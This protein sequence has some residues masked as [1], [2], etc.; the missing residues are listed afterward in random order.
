MSRASRPRQTPPQSAPRPGPGPSPFPAQPPGS[1]AVFQHDPLDA[2]L[3]ALLSAPSPAAQRRVAAQ[4]PA[5]TVQTAYTQ[6]P[7]AFVRSQ[8][9][10]GQLAQ[11]APHYAA[12]YAPVHAPRDQH[13]QQWQQQQLYQQQQQQR[14]QQE[15]YLQQQHGPMLPPAHEQ[16]YRVNNNNS[17]G[18]NG[19]QPQYPHQ[20]HHYAAATASNDN[21]HGYD[22]YGGYYSDSPASHQPQ[23][24]QY[25]QQQ[26]QQP[27]R[28]A[29]G[30][31][32]SQTQG[33]ATPYTPQQHH[34]SQQHHYQKQQQQQQSPYQQGYE[35]G[36]D[37]DY[38]DYQ[39]GQRPQYQP[40]HHQQQQQQ[41]QAGQ[42]APPAVMPSPA[43]VAAYDRVRTQPALMQHPR[44]QQQQQIGRAHV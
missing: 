10:H 17:H 18:Y 28:H 44:L 1:A 11:H 5:A 25:F 29:P 8:H 23:Q 41:Q 35:N 3:D 40:G 12:G 27:Q 20:P 6:P 37:Q 26:Q 34:H 7:D 36:H 24:Q 30:H 31:G 21:D 16:S 33:P 13:Q 38:G 4:L 19:P 39:Y 15:H 22:G 43:T 9:V 14:Q 32:Y 2:H 42:R